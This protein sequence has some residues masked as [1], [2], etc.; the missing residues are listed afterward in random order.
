MSAVQL[1]TRTVSL[2]PSYYELL[3][4]AAGGA[5]AAA[6]GPV[7]APGSGLFAANSRVARP[8]SVREPGLLRTRNGHGKESSEDS[9]MVILTPLF[10]PSRRSGGDGAGSANFGERAMDVQRRGLDKVKALEMIDSDLAHM[11]RPRFELSSP[12]SVE[13]PSGTLS[14][15]FSTCCRREARDLLKLIS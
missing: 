5:A 2:N 12:P 6:R 13:S 1:K 3:G 7:P 14:S 11:S 8:V 9:P 4:G 10:R 15:L